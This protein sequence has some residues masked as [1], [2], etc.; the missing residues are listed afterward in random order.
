MLI[1]ATLVYIERD[2][3]ILMLHRVKKE[4]DIH[5]GK[6]NGLG[7]K[8]EQGES[9]EEC[10]KR[11]IKEESGLIA[12]KLIFAGHISFPNFS[13]GD[14]WSVFIFRCFNFSGNLKN[15]D[16]GHLLWVEKSEIVSLNLWEGDK[17]FLPLVLS[18]KN[19]L[20]KI[21][22]K[23]TKLISVELSDIAT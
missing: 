15:C 12:K 2:N 7:G 14:D 22:Y 6:W 10:A 19:F 20:G 23:N 21:V 18:G 13:K 17:H 9:P 16:E 1:E 3:K 5:E 8:I 4:N 11:E